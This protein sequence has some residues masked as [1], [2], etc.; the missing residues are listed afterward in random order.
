MTQPSK[1]FYR[2]VMQACLFVA[3]AAA[4]V[5]QIIM[6]SFVRSG[7]CKTSQIINNLRQ[8][9][10][11]VCQWALDH[12]QTGAVAVTRQDIAA[13]LKDGW[14]RPVAGEKYILKLLSESP[15]AQLTR[16][17]DGRP[18]GTVFRW[19]TNTELEI[20]LPNQAHRSTH[21]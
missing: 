6:P 13:Y 17:V 1:P 20:V 15:E 12:R 18:K 9:D 2:R 16:E 4:G 7:P 19:R 3:C 10:G 21:P 11:A 5:W 14:V 8:L